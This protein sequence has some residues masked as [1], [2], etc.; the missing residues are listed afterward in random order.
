MTNSR[1]WT[2]TILPSGKDVQALPDSVVEFYERLNRL[3]RKDWFRSVMK[4]MGRDTIDFT[5]RACFDYFEERISDW[6]TAREH[7]FLHGAPSAIIGGSKP[8][9]P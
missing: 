2:F 7:G 3:V 6:K 9:G 8:G 4:I 5:Y 1:S